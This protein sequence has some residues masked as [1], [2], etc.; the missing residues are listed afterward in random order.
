MNFKNYDD[1]FKHYLLFSF[2]YGISNCGP[3]QW[4]LPVS[5]DGCPEQCFVCVFYSQ[6]KNWF[7]KK[8]KK[9]KNT[10]NNNHNNSNDNDNDSNS[11]NNNNNENDNF[12][13]LNIKKYKSGN[14]KSVTFPLMCM[15]ETINDGKAVKAEIND[16]S[17]KFEK[18]VIK[19]RRK[20]NR[21]LAICDLS[22]TPKNSKIEVRMNANTMT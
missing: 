21:F 7:K 17:L 12:I 3:N 11:N 18:I 2:Q 5:I 4:H 16:T 1:Y 19:W 6:N 15:W 8:N 20:R 13:Q 10:N 22:K 14:Y 9:K